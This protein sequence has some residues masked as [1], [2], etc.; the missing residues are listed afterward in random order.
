M[1]IDMKPASQHRYLISI[2]GKQVGPFD[3]RTIIGM[4]LK[5]LLDNNT[6][7][8]RSDGL[9]MTVA[10]LTMDRHETATARTEHDSAGSPLSGLWPSFLVNFGG[11][12][13]GSGALGF[14]GQGELRFQG[15]AL[16][17]TG[18]RNRLLFGSKQMRITVPLDGIAWTRASTRDASILELMLKPKQSFMKNIKRRPSQ[19]QLEDM[20]AVREL[21]ALITM[22]IQ[23][24][25]KI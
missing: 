14:T 18:L 1:L 21:L 5:K 8:L 3:R 2:H 11:G 12:W 16:R 23:P 15:G 20:D 25:S 19:I 4:R 7:L 6:A 10:E 9:P 17:L 24:A 22:D 13:T